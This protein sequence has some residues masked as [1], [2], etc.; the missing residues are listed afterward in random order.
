M[1][2][3]KYYIDFDGTIVHTVDAVVKILNYKHNLS[4]NPREVSTWDFT[5][6]F[7]VPM[8]EIDN[9]FS[10]R[11]FFENLKFIKGAK[12]FILNYIEDVLIVSKG[13]YENAKLKREFLNNNGLENV[14]FVC[15][16]HNISKGII[17]MSGG[18]FID[19]N[20]ENLKD[21]NAQVKILFKEYND[22]I[23]REWQ[24]NWNGFVSYSWN[25]IDECEWN[26]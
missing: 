24:N 19:D 3:Y 18:I 1:K 21:T 23:N 17:D 9:V 11:T 16:P 15:L 14:D 5:D 6:Q 22:D 10:D 12:N 7:K 2:N 25:N 20:V 4:V 26:I 8:I 13:D